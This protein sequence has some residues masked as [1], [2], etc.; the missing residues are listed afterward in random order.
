MMIKLVH[1]IK[2]M[3][4]VLVCGE[5]GVVCYRKQLI[6]SEAEIQRLNQLFIQ[7]RHSKIKVGPKHMRVCV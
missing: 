2:S 7:T 4:W 6:D 3:I 1:Y 5:R